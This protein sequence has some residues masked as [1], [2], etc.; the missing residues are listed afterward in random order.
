M[1]LGFVLGSMQAG[2]S[3]GTGAFLAELF[4]T[5]IRGAAQGFCGNAGRAVGS[6]F[7]LLVGVLSASIPLGVAMGICACSAYV[8]LVVFAFVLPET[9]GRELRSWTPE[10]VRS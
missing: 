5:R 9:R 2:T 8:V 3:A 6:L 10:A 4:P 7:P 1:L